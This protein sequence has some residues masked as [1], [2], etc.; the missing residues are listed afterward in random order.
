MVHSL[1]VPGVYQGHVVRM[2]KVTVGMVYKFV[3]LIPENL[4]RVGVY[5]SDDAV[6]KH[7][8]GVTRVLEKG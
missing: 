1:D 6:L 3:G 5:V 7:N 8:N 4:H 2:H